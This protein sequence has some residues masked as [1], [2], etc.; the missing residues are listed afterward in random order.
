MDQLLKEIE[1]KKSNL[2]QSKDKI[3]K[4]YIKRGDLERLRQEEYLKRQEEME[5]NRAAKKIKIAKAAISEPLKV[6]KKVQVE[7]VELDESEIKKRLRYHKQPITLFGESNTERSMRLQKVE[8]VEERSKAVTFKSLVDA[9]EQDLTEDLLKGD[10][11]DVEKET[12]EIDTTGI[13]VELIKNDL[14]FGC[15]LIIAYF[16]RLFRQWEKKMQSRPDDV[17]RSTKGKLQS[18]NLAQASEHLKPFW[19][20]LRKR[21]LA[22]DILIRIADVCRHLQNHS[23]NLANDAYIRLSIGNAPWPIGVTGSGKNPL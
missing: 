1:R 10:Q 5:R 19:D 6:L 8:S 13:S 4:K 14:D 23:F 17:K 2:D 12:E 21:N 9:N 22:M 7:I 3:G 11:A 16:Q 18:I 15:D 20:G